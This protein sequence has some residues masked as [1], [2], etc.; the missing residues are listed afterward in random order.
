MDKPMTITSDSKLE[1]THDKQHKYWKIRLKTW[2]QQGE[3]G[4]DDQ[5]VKSELLDMG[6]RFSAGSHTP[7]WLVKENDNKI[8]FM[9][10]E[11]KS[12]VLI[13]YDEFITKINVIDIPKII[14]DLKEIKE[15]CRERYGTIFNESPGSMPEH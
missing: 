4:W 12:N 10:G 5:Q 1:I 14:Y 3:E 2:S 9:L 11:R 15:Y 13:F 6:I 8:W 7:L